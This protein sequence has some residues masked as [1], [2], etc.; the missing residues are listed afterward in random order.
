MIQDYLLLTHL[1]IY[2]ISS[3]TG[4]READI[5]FLSMIKKMGIIE[6]IIFIVNCD[7]SEHESMADLKSLL[8]KVE[9]ELALITT[10]PD[11]YSISALFNLFKAQQNNLSEKDLNRLKQ[12]QDEIELVSFSESETNRFETSFYKILTKERYALLLKNHLE[13]LDVITRGMDHWIFAHKSIISQDA[14]NTSEVIEKVKQHQDRINHIKSMIKHTFDG[15]IQKINNEL[16][17]DVDRFFDV[18]SGKILQAI[19]GFIKDYKIPPDQYEENLKASGFSNTLYLIFQEFKQ[20]LDSF[21][22]ELI[23]P[24]IIRFL[25][26]KELRIQEHL[27]SIA[28]PFDTLMQEAVVEYNR[29]TE[30]FETDHQHDNKKTI[31][32]L[33]IDPIKDIVGLTIPPATASIRYTAKVKTEA[34]MRL[35][36]YTVVKIFK[37]LL[38]KPIRSNNEEEVLALK[39]G[40][41]RM[42]HDTEKSIVFHFKDYRENIK[43]QYIFKLVEALSNSYYQALLNRFRTHVADLS[44]IV[45]LIDNEQIDKEKAF[46]VLQ[47]MEV[48]S[49]KIKNRIRDIRQEIAST[50]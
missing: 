3:R 46:S 38:R 50:I 13:R 32:P 22:A 23:N 17:A 37:R 26:E 30:G 14:V 25:K 47:E 20:S 29:M 36:F 43:Y 16:K 21:M 10:N 27:I 9:E 49:K 41:S 4:L 6:N 34:V 39:D 15:G 31:E 48:S 5:K 19:T 1:I 28:G 11:T 40:I 44:D 2:V 33:P 7:F 12:W 42:K 45:D 8:T 24:E 35:G 18:R